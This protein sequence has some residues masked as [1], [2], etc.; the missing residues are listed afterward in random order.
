M[1]ISDDNYLEQL[2]LHNEKALMYVIGQYGGLLRS[3]VRKHLHGLPDCQDECLN[4]IFMGIWNNA[5]DFDSSKNSFQNW[6]AGIARYKSMDY[7]RKHYRRT[8]CESIEAVEIGCNDAYLEQMIEQKVSE[9][10]E[11]MLACLNDVDQ[12]IFRK[13]YVEEM[14][15]DEVSSKTGMKKEMIYN[16]MSRGK[17]RIQKQYCKNSEV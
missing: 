2:Q 9:E 11:Q 13:I 6:I 14:G 8:V 17:K 1:K 12:D 16:R 10:L 5:R 7:L 15:I 3:I 4:D